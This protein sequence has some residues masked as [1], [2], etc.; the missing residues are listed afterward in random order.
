MI[1]RMIMGL[2]TRNR[3]A[4]QATPVG[5]QPKPASPVWSSGLL[6]RIARVAAGLGLSS[7]RPGPPAREG[8]IIARER[9]DPASAR[10]S[11]GRSIQ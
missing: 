8:L 4:R 9:T 10:A 5:G 3:M 11:R 7:G 1:K 2:P 6:L